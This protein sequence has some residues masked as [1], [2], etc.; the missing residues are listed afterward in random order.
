VTSII[1]LYPRTVF[2]I[3]KEFEPFVPYNPIANGKLSNKLQ[4]DSAVK[5]KLSSI[6]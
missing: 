1:S 4:I 2:F 3:S 6:Q 5:L